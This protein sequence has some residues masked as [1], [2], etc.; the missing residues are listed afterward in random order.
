MSPSKQPDV[1]FRGFFA[2]FSLVFSW[3]IGIAWG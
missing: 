2:V 3:L 1:F